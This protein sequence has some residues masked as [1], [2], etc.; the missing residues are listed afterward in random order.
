MSNSRLPNLVDRG[1]FPESERV[2]KRVYTYRG[3]LK[4]G[5]KNQFYD[6]IYIKS[7]YVTLQYD[8]TEAPAGAST[9][10]RA[11]RPCRPTA[12]LL[13]VLLLVLVFFSRDF[14]DDGEHPLAEAK[15]YYTRL[16]EPIQNCGLL[17]LAMGR[18]LLVL[19][20]VLMFCYHCYYY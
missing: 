1:V 6:N 7:V 17:A 19:V 3:P 8:I 16:A 12:N 20:L 2:L 15:V 11:R 18:H 5:P 9:Q 13:F 14:A 10:R 4:G